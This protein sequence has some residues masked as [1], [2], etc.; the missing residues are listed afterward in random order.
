MGRRWRSHVFDLR[1]LL[2][3]AGIADFPAQHRRERARN[4]RRVGQRRRG[5]LTI[6]KLTSALRHL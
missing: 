5:G 3:G 4:S 2:F 6:G 1:R